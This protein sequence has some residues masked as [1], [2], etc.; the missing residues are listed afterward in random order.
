MHN[1]ATIPPWV[2][3]LIDAALRYVPKDFV[4]QIEVNM[5]RGGISNVNI[6]QSFK[7]EA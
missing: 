7:R 2:D 3:Q 1:Q 4:G 5:F 6:K